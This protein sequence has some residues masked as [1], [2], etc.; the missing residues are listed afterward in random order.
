MLRGRT[1]ADPEV[2]RELCGAQGEHHIA[3]HVDDGD[4]A[5]LRAVAI[6][7]LDHLVGAEWPAID[8][9]LGHARDGTGMIPDIVPYC[10]VSSV[11]SFG[12]RN[13]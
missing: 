9:N 7:D 6:G 4:R 2:V 1:G 10:A 13:A 12:K 11:S 3:R 8:D 5:L